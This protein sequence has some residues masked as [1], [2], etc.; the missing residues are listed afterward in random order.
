MKAEPTPGSNAGPPK[1]VASYEFAQ[2]KGRINTIEEAAATLTAHEAAAVLGVN[3]QP[4]ILFKQA[5]IVEA[6][7]V[8]EKMSP[9]ETDGRWLEEITKHVEPLVKEWDIAHA[10][11]RASS[12]PD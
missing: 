1:A 6:L 2:G 9:L 3:E 4:M 7:Q 11:P 8:V 10:Y 5:T 12:G